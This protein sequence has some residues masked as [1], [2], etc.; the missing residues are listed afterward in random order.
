MEDLMDIDQKEIFTFQVKKGEYSFNFKRC[1]EVNEIYRPACY[2]EVS[3][4]FENLSKNKND[5]SE[6]IKFCKYLGNEVYKMACIKQMAYRAITGGY[7]RPYDMCKVLENDKQKMICY[8]TYGYRLASSIPE[9][10]NVP[11]HTEIWQNVCDYMNDMDA[12]KCFE[13]I[14]KNSKSLYFTPEKGLNF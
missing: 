9:V 5:Y 6:N 7:K 4:L 13:N 14:A 1:D 12:K 10:G 3:V 8:A 11:K 2:M